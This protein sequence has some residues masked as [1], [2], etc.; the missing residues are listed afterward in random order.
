MEPQVHNKT[1]K[2]QPPT[3]NKTIEK[4][5]N[6]LSE[7][8]IE[9]ELTEEQFSS[10]L[11]GVRIETGR[12]IVNNCELL[13]VG[14]VLHD[15]GHLACLPPSLKHKAND[16]IAESLGEQHSYEMAVILW[17]YAAAKF[18]NIPLKQIFLSDGYKS[19]SEWIIEQLE[20]QEFMGLPLLQWLGLAASN[21]E[22]AK[23]AAEPFPA[24]H[25]WVRTS[26]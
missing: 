12:L 3:F 17:T 15:A 26:E 4:V 22:I 25:K 6:F 21:D 11:P 16:N 13:C 18:L 7:I 19:N 20:N 24:M 2:P 10:F 5:I 14:D 9:V 23:G 1:I 8:G